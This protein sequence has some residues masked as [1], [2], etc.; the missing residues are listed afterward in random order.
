MH[1]CL[2]GAVSKLCVCVVHEEWECVCACLDWIIRLSVSCAEK[3][4]ATKTQSKLEHSA[5]NQTEEMVRLK[6]VVRCP[7]GVTTWSDT[8]SCL[9]KYL[10]CVAGTWEC[11]AALGSCRWTCACKPE[12][13]GKEQTAPC[14]R[15]G[16]LTGR[17][18]CTAAGGG[19]GGG[20][21]WHKQLVS[22]TECLCGRSF[23]F[24]PRWK[25]TTLSSSAWRINTGQE[26]WFTLMGT[27]TLESLLCYVQNVKNKLQFLRLSTGGQPLPDTPSVH[28]A[29]Q[30]RVIP[31]ADWLLTF[32]IPASWLVRKEPGLCSSEG[33][34]RAEFL[35]DSWNFQTVKIPDF[36]KC[37]WT[38]RLTGPSD[39]EKQQKFPAALERHIFQAQ[40]LESLK[41]V[42]L[43]LFFNNTQVNCSTL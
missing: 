13:R 18:C 16:S 10:C 5:N 36:K 9:S 25:G 17:L 15:W 29:E 42:W 24:L 3:I 19:G 33:S 12:R 32:Q 6:S 23:T 39:T 14:G 43:S 26:M 11:L 31:S 34:R 1:E 4:T 21:C 38:Q 40:F 37:P 20:Q 7:H 8:Y 27:R 22:C 30:L 35:K 28:T 41:T 2:A